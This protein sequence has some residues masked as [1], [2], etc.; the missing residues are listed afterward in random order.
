M[1]DSGTVY[2]SKKDWWIVLLV[3]FAIV[4]MLIAGFDLL[5]SGEA[6]LMK[7]GLSVFCFLVAGLCAW[8]LF[9]T[10]YVLNRE[11]VRIACGPIRFRV[12]LLDIV[13]IY[14]TRNPLSSPALSLDRL[15]IRTG[16]WRGVMIS[17]Q[18]REGFM[19]RLRLL[20]TGLRPSDKDGLERR[21]REEGELLDVDAD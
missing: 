12:R 15:M 2:A 16:K 6:P 5:Q 9:G 17:P 1:T 4:M 13:E 14:P 19:R 11:E 10:R 3:L 21:A 18:D 20:D 8:M 7:Y